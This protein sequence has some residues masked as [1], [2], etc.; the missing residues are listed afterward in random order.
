VAQMVCNIAFLKYAMAQSNKCCF[1]PFF[2][3]LSVGAFLK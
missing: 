2:N 1:T 3:T